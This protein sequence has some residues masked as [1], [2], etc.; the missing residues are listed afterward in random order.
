MITLDKQRDENEIDEIEKEEDTST[1]FVNGDVYKMH[2]YRDAIQGVKA[3]FVL[4]PGHQEDF[5]FY[6][7]EG[8]TP[9][10]RTKIEEMEEVLGVGAVALRPP[11]L[12]DK[13]LLKL[14]SRILDST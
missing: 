1:T 7:A 2:T 4:Y 13:T 3:A 9:T 14:L 5:R 12:G 10:E 8:H 11:T 6:E